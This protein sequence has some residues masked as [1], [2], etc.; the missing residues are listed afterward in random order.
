[1]S[2]RIFFAAACPTFGEELRASC[3]RVG[4]AVAAY[5]SLPRSIERRPSRDQRKPLL[6]ARSSRETCAGVTGTGSGT[7][8][9]RRTLIRRFVTD[10]VH[11]SC[12]TAVL[13]CLRNSGEPF[14][15]PFQRAAHETLRTDTPCRRLHA[16]D[17]RI[18]V[19][20]EQLVGIVGRVAVS[21]KGNL[22]SKGSRSWRFG[23][24]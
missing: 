13:Q 4:S 5:E 22:I 23:K 10:R 12:D 16:R 6:R 17:T 1:M 7:V 3:R 21:L 24:I 15:C 19:L 18:G 8:D 9:R 11:C 2:T 14:C 20:L